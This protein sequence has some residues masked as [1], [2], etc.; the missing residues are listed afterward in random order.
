[1]I[2]KIGLRTSHI[3]CCAALFH[4]GGGFAVPAPYRPGLGRGPPLIVGQ[5]RLCAALQKQTDHAGLPESGHPPQRRRTEILIAGMQISTMAIEAQNMSHTSVPAPG[6]QNKGSL[7]FNSSGW[8][9]LGSLL[10]SLH[11]QTGHG[12]SAPLR[13]AVCK[14]LAGEQVLECNAVLLRRSSLRCRRQDAHPSILEKTV[15]LS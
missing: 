7:L 4:Q 15:T 9:M 1:M 2:A 6:D 13:S 12:S 3:S 11:Y 10:R 8:I 14:F 5:V